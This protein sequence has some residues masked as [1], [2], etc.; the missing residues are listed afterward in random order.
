VGGA[1]GHVNVVQGTG[2][3]TSLRCDVGRYARGKEQGN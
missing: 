2:P 1:S 3:T